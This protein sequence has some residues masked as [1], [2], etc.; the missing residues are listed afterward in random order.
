MSVKN[1]TIVVIGGS[2]GLG[3]GIAIE[4]AN[5]GAMVTI[6][7][8]SKEKLERSVDEI[9]HNANYHCVDVSSEDSIK[10]L[11]EQLGEIDHLV[12]TSGFV[13]GKSF[14]ALSF[15]E[16]R[17]DVEINVWGKFNVVKCGASFIKKTG[18]ITFI[19]GAFATKPNPDVFMTTVSVAAV[20]AMAKTLAIA[21][22]PVRVNA[23]SPYVVDTTLVGGGQSAEARKDFLDATAQSLPSKCIG[24][25]K[26][27]GGAAVFLMS[28]PYVTGS[29][30]SVD[31]GFTLI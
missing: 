2:S 6:A 18:S 27:I 21:L 31:G 14:D 16:A 17:N 30:L 9:G 19:S 4:C 22:S 20:E 25:P 28:N 12:V 23:I 11:F 5:Q 3:L 1:A 15:E 7:S 29:I 8:R 26:D 13:T 24:R 10:A